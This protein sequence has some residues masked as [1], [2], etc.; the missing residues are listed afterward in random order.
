LD[1]EMFCP[2]Y[3]QGALPSFYKAHYLRYL[4]PLPL[5]I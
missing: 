5:A 2:A 4:T 1:F 3:L